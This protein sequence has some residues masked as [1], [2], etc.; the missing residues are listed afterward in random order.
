MK[1]LFATQGKYGERIAEYVSANRPEGWEILRLP[2]PRSLPM[3]IDDPDEVL[4]TEIPAA[5]L[6]VSLHESS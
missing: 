6:L 3:V 2:L 4:P 5:D 1:V